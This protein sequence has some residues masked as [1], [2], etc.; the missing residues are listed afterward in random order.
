MMAPRGAQQLA[1]LLL[2]AAAVSC[3][4]QALQ[5]AYKFSIART[6]QGAYLG[7]YRTSALKLD[8]PSAA[9]LG[10]WSA[11]KCPGYCRY[12]HRPLYAITRGFQCVCTAAVPHPEAQ[13][14]DAQCERLASGD[15]TNAVVPLFYVH[16]GVQGCLVPP[17]SENIRAGL[18]ITGLCN[19]TD[20]RSNGCDVRSCCG[21]SMLQ[22]RPGAE[23]VPTTTMRRP[24]HASSH[25]SAS[26]A[27]RFPQTTPCTMQSCLRPLPHPLPPSPPPA[28]NKMR[29]RAKRVSVTLDTFEPAYNAMN[30]EFYPDNRSVDLYMYVSTLP[31]L[32]GI[33]RLVSVVPL[34]HT[35]QPCL[36]GMQR[37][38]H[39]PKGS[40]CCASS[41]RCPMIRF[42]SIHQ[43]P[44]GLG[45]KGGCGAEGA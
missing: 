4:A 23:A 38:Q 45:H 44:T 30:A 21:H 34:H 19:V 13:V 28:D 10:S 41:R 16:S 12:S 36:N 14:D 27:P 35:P 2:V 22:Q 9:T 6:E 42:L 29:C 33:H 31:P 5:P 1:V 25:F 40:R 43:P 20:C 32:F 7:C 17:Q 18:H 24:L 8:W 26:L 11:S 3:S 39:G 15:R 37:G